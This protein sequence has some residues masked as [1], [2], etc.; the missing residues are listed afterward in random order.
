MERY[1][2]AVIGAGPGGAIH[3]HP[4]PTECLTEAAHAMHSECIHLSAGK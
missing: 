3:A 2:I 4:T 1:D